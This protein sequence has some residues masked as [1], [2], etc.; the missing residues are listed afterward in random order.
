[1]QLKRVGSVARRT[2]EPATIE[3]KQIS[4]KVEN[5]RLLHICCQRYTPMPHRIGDDFLRR[6]LDALWAMRNKNASAA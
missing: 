2:N 1:M 5:S 6:I 3:S 4:A